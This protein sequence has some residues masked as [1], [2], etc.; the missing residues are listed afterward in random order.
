MPW[1]AARTGTVLVVGNGLSIGCSNAFRGDELTR[2]ALAA[3]PTDSLQFVRALAGISSWEL[4]GGE[5]P[6]TLGFEGLA[7]PIDRLSDVVEYIPGTRNLSDV[8]S[9]LRREYKRLVACVL[10]EVHRAGQSAIPAFEP[11]TP[12]LEVRQRLAAMSPTA[13]E[14]RP[15]AERLQR[16]ASQRHRDGLGRTSLFTLNY[17]SMLDIGLDPW[18][19]VHG[20]SRQQARRQHEQ[21]LSRSAFLGPGQ[22]PTDDAA[23]EVQHLHGDLYLE[24]RGN[25]LRWMTLTELERTLT[26]WQKGQA[27]DVDPVVVLGNWKS[28]TVTRWP[29]SE[30]YDR[31]DQCLSQADVCVVAGYGFGDAPVNDRLARFAG[32]RS[33]R[34]HV[35][36]VDPATRRRAAAALHLNRPSH[37]KLT[38]LRIALPDPSGFDSL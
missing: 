20:L 3:L 12:R 7:G 38:A 25:G 9:A 14:I 37:R 19:R 18:W 31:L 33:T 29:F 21:V 24:R 28:K 16:F 11:D 2:K 35:W 17:D 8:R 10:L 32:R 36:S 22:E 34:V 30:Y 27:E 6:T 15:F 26:R 5:D 4:G 13:G 1:D 23:L